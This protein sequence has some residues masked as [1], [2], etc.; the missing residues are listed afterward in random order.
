[1]I[2][3]VGHYKNSRRNLLKKARILIHLKT[4]IFFLRFGLPSTRKRRFSGI[5]NAGFL[6]RSSEW[7]FFENPGLS[8][9]SYIIQRMPRKACNCV[10]IV[11]AFMCGQA[12]ETILRACLH[13]VGDPG[14]VGLVSFVFTLWGT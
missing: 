7:C 11:F 13:G 2:S 5:K 10:S 14:L 9:S 1:M 3:I 6:K 12:G 4:E 8:F